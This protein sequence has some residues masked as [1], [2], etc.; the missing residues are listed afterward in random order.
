MSNI[1]ILYKLLMKTLMIEDLLLFFNIISTK[2][3]N[4]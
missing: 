3:N 2:Y 4:P 1:N